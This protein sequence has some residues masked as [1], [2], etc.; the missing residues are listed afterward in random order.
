MKTL[1]TRIEKDVFGDISIPY[2]KIDVIKNI[3]L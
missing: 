2:G 1:K 3:I